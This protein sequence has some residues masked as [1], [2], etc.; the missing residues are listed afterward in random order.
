MKKLLLVLAI[1][2]FGC[3]PTHDVKNAG[4]PGPTVVVQKADK[5]PEPINEVK[6]KTVD[7]RPFH[8]DLVLLSMA[9]GKPVF[10]Y[11]KDENC[12]FCKKMDETTFSNDII[13]EL[14]N[15]ALIPTS[16]DIM[17]NPKA[18]SIFY[19]ED[20]V[21]VPKFVFIQPRKSGQWIVVEATGYANTFKMIDIIHEAEEFIKETLDE[22]KS[23]K[24]SAGKYQGIPA[25]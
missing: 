22:E 8:D 19:K 5:K 11:L 24:E 10:V 17:E 15:K 9:L 25:K 18:A 4:S 13:I 1:V 20:S 14:I 12:G 21:T 7:W 2:L 16:I 23:H 3:F 6:K